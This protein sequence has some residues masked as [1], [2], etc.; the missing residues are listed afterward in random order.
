MSRQRRSFFA[1]ASA[2]LGLLSVF[3]VLCFHFPELLTSRE[4]RA[5]YS[6]QATAARKT[7]ILEQSI[8][9]LRR[10]VDESGTKEP[11]IVRQGDDRWED[12]VRW[13]FYAM[14]NAEEL[15]VTSQNIDE[16]LNSQNP[17]IRR[18]LG[19]EGDFG[20]QLGLTKDWAVRIIR[21]VGNYGEIFERNVGS[22]SPLQI[23][24]G[25]NALWTNGGL[26]YAPPIR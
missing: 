4:F 9:I 19:I 8:E 3:A 26:Q 6:E 15:G 23:A 11:T 5:V 25:K 18:L 22:G 12:L 2:M 16:Q 10:R 1:Y 13:T 20:E 21:K 24:R 7:Q 14:V 17:E